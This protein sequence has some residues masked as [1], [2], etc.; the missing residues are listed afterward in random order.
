MQ[1]QPIT[2]S[3]VVKCSIHNYIEYR[4][5][6]QIES[7]NLVYPQRLIDCMVTYNFNLKW[8]RARRSETENLEKDSVEIDIEDELIEDDEER[9]ELH[10]WLKSQI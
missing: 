1:E 9:V 8:D 5:F 10:N 4:I 6:A 2:Q 7:R 3:K